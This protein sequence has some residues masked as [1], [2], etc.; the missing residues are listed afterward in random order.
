MAQPD[1]E[2]RVAEDAVHENRLGGG[3]AEGA[4]RGRGIILG[5]QIGLGLVRW[6][7]GRPAAGC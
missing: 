5:L 3:Q 2:E 7:R 4:R 6:R 1:V